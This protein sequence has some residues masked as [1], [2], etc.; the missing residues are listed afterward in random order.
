M[1]DARNDADLR[2]I[3]QAMVEEQTKTQGEDLLLR[4]DAAKE[5]FHFT[6]HQ[7][8]QIKASNKT[9]ATAAKATTPKG[10]VYFDEVTNKLVV[11][12]KEKSNIGFKRKTKDVLDGVGS[13][14]EDDDTAPQKAGLDKKKSNGTT[15]KKG[16]E[17]TLAARVL[18]KANM[19]KK[20]EALHFVRE[21]GDTY[22]AKGQTKGDVMIPGKAAPH[23]FVQLNPMVC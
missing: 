23:A 7:I 8:F 4:F 9:D 5:S 1:L 16:E 22:R 18:R 17:E 20:G 2:Q 19:Q 12:E 21:S 11:R 14:D 15:V 6:K 3:K 13:D 10:E